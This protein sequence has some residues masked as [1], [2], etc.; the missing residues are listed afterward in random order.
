MKKSLRKN[1]RSYGYA[2]KGLKYVLKN[3][4]NIRYQLVA[5]ITALLLGYY[6]NISMGEWLTIIVIIGLVLTAEIFNTA[7]E[8]L[9]DHVNPEQHPVA[10]LVKDISAGAVL[11]ISFTAAAVGAIIFIPYFFE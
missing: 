2:W 4:N 11:L 6:Q 3:E 1:I 9:V 8:K 10:G 5:G 7:L